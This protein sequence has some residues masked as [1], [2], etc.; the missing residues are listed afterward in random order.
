[1]L[2]Q[3]N[4]KLVGFVIA[5]AAGV[6]ICAILFI[7]PQYSI[8]DHMHRKCLDRIRDIATL[9]HQEYQAPE[10]FIIHAT[11]KCESCFA[12][13]NSSTLWDMEIWN[14]LGPLDSTE[15]ADCLSNA[16]RIAEAIGEH[17][18][19]AL[20]RCMVAAMSTSNGKQQTIVFIPVVVRCLAPNEN[21]KYLVEATG[22]ACP[23]MA[24]VPAL[25][26]PSNGTRKDM[27]VCPFA[28]ELRCGFASFDVVV[29]AAQ[30]ANIPSAYL[31]LNDGRRYALGIQ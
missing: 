5:T 2:I 14:S 24:L 3:L 31:L 22:A 10:K 20:C 12:S 21:L 15:E 26:S 25:K 19:P 28:R 23:V 27:L 1:M 8:N 17:D 13:G 11:T 18:E 30:W 9:I 29:R 4:S 6:L 16:E 7:K